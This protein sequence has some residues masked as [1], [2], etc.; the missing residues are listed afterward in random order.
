V[1]KMYQGSNKEA[2]ILSSIEN[3]RMQLHQ[4]INQGKELLDPQV[5]IKSQELDT[6]LNKFYK[7]GSLKNTYLNK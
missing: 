2:E 1:A 5:L 3:L 6:V 4:K 7:L